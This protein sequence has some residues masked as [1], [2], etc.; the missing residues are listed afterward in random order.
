M[1]KHQPGKSPGDRVTKPSGDLNWSAPVCA[2]KSNG[3]GKRIKAE[4]FQFVVPTTLTIK[5]VQDSDYEEWVI[6]AKPAR[7]AK[8][9]P[10]HLEVWYGPTS[11]GSDAPAEL[12]KSTAVVERGQWSCDRLKG[13]DLAGVSAGGV[14]WRWISL[15]LGQASYRTTS[16]DLAAQFDLV[17]N[18]LCCDLTLLKQ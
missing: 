16:K 15:P 3:P 4:T 17:L 5:K 9:S 10:D 18:S 8:A 13:N 11:V 6:F 14:H 2:S 7:N 1:N 12:T